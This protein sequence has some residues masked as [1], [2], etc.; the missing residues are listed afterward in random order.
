MGVMAFQSGGAVGL[1]IRQNLATF[2]KKDKNAPGNSRVVT[3]NLFNKSV[4]KKTFPQSNQP[5]QQQS[6]TGVAEGSSAQ[7]KRGL[8][9]GVLT[10]DYGHRIQK[11]VELHVDLEGILSVQYVV[12]PANTPSGL[13]LWL[14]T[15]I[16]GLDDIFSVQVTDIG[17]ISGA[18]N[19]ILS[20]S[21]AK[22]VSSVT[23]PSKE[24]FLENI[25]SSSN[26]DEGR[27]IKVD[28]NYAIIRGALVN[29]DNIDNLVENLVKLGKY[30]SGAYADG[31][32]NANLGTPFV[33]VASKI[34]KANLVLNIWQPQS[35]M[36]SRN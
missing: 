29:T 6:S 14:T 7:P 13:V 27:L 19:N 34:R 18:N 11:D 5:A 32:D 25:N 24:V 28:L 21:V 22:A 16:A 20:F 2:E 3:E 33:N 31:N 17:Q 8:K 9:S 1:Q 23:K 10:A 26:E 12:T 15:S 36:D 35:G 4:S 30:N